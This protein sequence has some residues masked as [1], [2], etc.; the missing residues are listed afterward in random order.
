MPE[1][2]RERFFG[3]CRSLKSAKLRNAS[4]ESA[5]LRGANLESADLHGARLVG[6]D[7]SDADLVGANFKNIQWDEFTKWQ[8]I[9]GWDQVKNIPPAL[10]Q[11]LRLQ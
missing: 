3:N 4:L 9:Q 1:Y 5:E 10:K 8:G 11:K 6:A 2:F 7:L